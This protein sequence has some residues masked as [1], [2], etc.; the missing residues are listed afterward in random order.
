IAPASRRDLLRRSELRA[1][2]RRPDVE[3]RVKRE[4]VALDDA[5]FT[6]VELLVVVEAMIVTALGSAFV[7]VMNNSTTV[8]ESLARTNDARFAASYIVSDARNS[9]GPETSLSDT[10]SC[11]D[12]SPP[13]SGSATPVVRFNWSGT[14]SAGA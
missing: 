8:K 10:A 14:T 9:S 5:G 1:S 3:Q 6:M 2:R 12:P 4:R 7:L 13:V 11:P